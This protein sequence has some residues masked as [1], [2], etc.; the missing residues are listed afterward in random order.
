MGG[1]WAITQLAAPHAA[2]KPAF[3]PPSWGSPKFHILQGFEVCTVHTAYRQAGCMVA[4][5]FGMRRDV[6]ARHEHEISGGYVKVLGEY[7]GGF[8]GL[9]WGVVGRESNPVSCQP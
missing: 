3:V 2:T 1:D 9:L 5:H 8:L 7:A 6:E 4:T